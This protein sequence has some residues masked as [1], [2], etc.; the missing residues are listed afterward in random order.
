[1]KTCLITGGA[2]GIGRATVRKFAEEGY[3]CVF[4]YEKNDEAAEETRRLYGAVPVKCDIADPASCA[5]A[6]ETALRLLGHVDALVLNAGIS[7][8]D[9]VQDMTPEAFHRVM[10]VNAYGAY[11]TVSRVA[12]SMISR[13]SGTIVTVASIW[14]ET[15]GSMESAYSASKGAVIAMTK[16]L[17]KE[18]GPSGIRVNCVSPGVIETE[19]NAHLGEETLR[20]LA[21]DTP[22]ERNGQPGE[23]AEAIFFLASDAAS[24]ITG[25]VLG[26]NGGMYI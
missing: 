9:L 13:R 15:G 25:Q 21:E 19:M 20:E 3:S 1:M 24:F 26:V 4:F 2:R 12:P 5:S 8:F 11:Q 22:L 6:C 18:L 10:D 14:G 23:V 7:H 16:A 17:A